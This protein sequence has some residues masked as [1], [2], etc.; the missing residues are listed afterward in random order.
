MLKTSAPHP[1]WDYCTELKAYIRSHTAHDLYTL[2]GEVPETLMTGL[3]AD[4]SELCE[5]EWY[6]WVYLKQLPSLRK[7]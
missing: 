4:I 6:Q 5:F 1:L 2:K 3:T 7:K